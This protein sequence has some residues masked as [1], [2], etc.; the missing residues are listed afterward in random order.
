MLKEFYCSE[1]IASGILSL[2]SVEGSQKTW[3]KKNNKNT[4]TRGEHANR[5]LLGLKPGNSSYY[6]ISSYPQ[7]EELKL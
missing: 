6:I 4:Y 7:N 5:L 3:D 2:K 1:I